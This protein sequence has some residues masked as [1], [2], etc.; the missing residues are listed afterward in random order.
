M[1]TSRAAPIMVTIRVN[2][3][4]SQI[5]LDTG[6]SVSNISESTTEDCGII[7]TEPEFRTPTSDCEHIL[8]KV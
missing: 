8:A 7:I 5:E 3:C 2:G 6:D 4:D 1:I